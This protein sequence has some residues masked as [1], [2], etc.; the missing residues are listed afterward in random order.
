MKKSDKKSKDPPEDQ[1][2]INNQVSKQKVQSKSIRKN[3]IENP[4]DEN[5]NIEEQIVENN[6]GPIDNPI[7]TYLISKRNN[8]NDIQKKI[9]RSLSMKLYIIIENHE[10]LINLDTVVNKILM[11]LTFYQK[12]IEHNKIYREKF[13][14]TTFL[15]IIKDSINVPFWNSK[16]E[17][18]AKG[19][20]IPHSCMLIK[21]ENFISKSWFETE[22]MKVENDILC[23]QEVNFEPLNDNDDKKL[24][25]NKKISLYPD[26]IQGLVLRQMFG[27]YRYYYN[28]T[29]S[30]LNNLD[31]APPR[32]ETQSSYYLIDPKKQD[33]KITV[34]NI[35]KNK[36]QLYYYLN[37]VLKLNP[38]SW[39]KNV[40]LPSHVISEAIKEAIVRLFTNLKIFAK[41]HRPFKMKYKTKK[42]LVQTMNIGKDMM[43]KTGIFPRLEYKGKYIFKELNMSESYKKFDYCGSSISYHRRL[44]KYTLNLNYKTKPTKNTS[45]KVCSIDPGVKNFITVYSDSKVAKIGI[46]TKDKL[47]KVCKEIDI[48][49]SRICRKSFHV[50]D[51][52]SGERKEYKVNNKRRMNLIRA[53]H[54]KIQ[55]LKNLKSD[56]H[57]KAINYL[58]KNFSKIIIPPF[59][60][61]KM[62]GKLSSNTARMMYNLSYYTF[63]QKLISK[64][65]EMNCLVVEKPEYYTSKTCTK[66]GNIKH[67]LKLSDRIYECNRCGLQLDRDY[68]AARNIMLRNH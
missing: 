29:I 42:N 3:P 31:K 48:I 35:P 52:N 21:D 22:F 6:I 19:L 59:E 17:L 40:K 28:R 54:R 45:N 49:E 33:S 63:K 18:F 58:C 13:S 9:M 30:I 43:G 11:N 23:L 41:T 46:N 12:I 20:F 16:I 61:K 24:I 8:F 10:Y 36:I 34:L 53:K 5:P 55:K 51:K 44:N 25:K 1:K 57:N 15:E 4:I 32:E 37:S 66:C 64:A 68:A 14:A 62:A 7:Y 39:I 27:I 56:L 65:R 47:Y 60:I 50:K 26:A 2:P 67:D 38:P